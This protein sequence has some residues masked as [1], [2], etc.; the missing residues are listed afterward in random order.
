[1]RSHEEYL[2][3]SLARRKQTSKLVKSKQGRSQPS[4]SEN[5]YSGAIILSG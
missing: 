2:D 1:M 5:D 4:L 3:P